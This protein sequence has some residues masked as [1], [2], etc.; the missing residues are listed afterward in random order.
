LGSP[1]AKKTGRI[2]LSR[3]CSLDHN[4]SLLQLQQNPF[5]HIS[6]PII[7]KVKSGFLGSQKKNPA[8]LSCG[9]EFLSL[10]SL[11]SCDVALSQK[12][13]ERTMT[14]RSCEC[15]IFE[16]KIESIND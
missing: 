8:D 5:S 11:G 2:L 4:P 14:G 3:K 6:L 9:F 7:D 13:S 16:S 15:Q 1:K 10:L 12:D